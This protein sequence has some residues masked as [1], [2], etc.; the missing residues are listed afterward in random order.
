MSTLQIP[1]M[2]STT[3][4]LFL[5]GFL[6]DAT[7]GFFEDVDTGPPHYS[8]LHALR[9]QQMTSV[10]LETNLMQPMRLPLLP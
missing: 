2:S 6:E 8:V 5:P 1:H 9:P 7:E 10:S 4:M 3:V